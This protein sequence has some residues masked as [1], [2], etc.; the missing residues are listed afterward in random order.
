M[1]DHPAHPKPRSR[2]TPS[3]RRDVLIDRAAFRLVSSR[4]DRPDD[5]ELARIEE[6]IRIALEVFD[7][8]RWIDEPASYHRAP[9]PAEGM[10]SA[11]RRS[12][13]VRYVGLSWL[14]GYAPHP[15]EPGS[16]RFLAYPRNNVAR[17]MVLEHRSTAPPWLVILHGFGMGS[18]ALDL[19]AFRALRL[20]RDLG[21]NVAFLTLP[22]H[23][24]RSSGPITRPVMPSAD[25][26]DTVHG[27]T[28]AVWDTRQLLAH[29]RARTDQPIGLLGL[30]LGGLVAALVASL[31]KPDAAV[32]VVP[33]VDL[34]GL[35][36]D[37]T[38]SDM[39][40]ADDV[41][42]GAELLRRAQPI[43]APVSPLQL[44][45]RVPHA[46]RT[47]IAGTLDQFARPSTQA[48]EIWRHWDE[49]ELHWYHGG[50]ASVFWASGV[51]DSIDTALRH[52]GL[53]ASAGSR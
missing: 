40:D 25:V 53:V 49:P 39:L 9:P 1:H 14:D 41:D 16:D 19:R 37:A 6:E 3:V 8:E 51:Q 32:L 43:F 21:L 31:D 20:H 10:R 47:V 11:S 38:A 50:H 52:A 36:A 29:L 15:H 5:G 44:T 34:P 45:P 4:V 23:G 46:H 12:G 27:V 42:L 22:F 7:R 18:A 35:M 17:A 2:L 48:V 30:S 24:Q 28:Q 13:T 26:M 33:A